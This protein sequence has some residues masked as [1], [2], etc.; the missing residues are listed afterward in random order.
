MLSFILKRVIPTPKLTGFSRYLFI[1][2]HPDDIEVGCAPTVAALT[3]AG[4]HVAF[5]VVTDG[6]V[7]GLDPALTG[8]PLAESRR[9]EALASAKLLGVTDVTFLPFADGGRYAQQD[10]EAALAAVI[11][12][13]QPDVVFAPDPDV[14]AEC[15]PDHLKVGAAAKTCFCMTGFPAL[16]QR[17]GVGGAH[18]V[19]LLALYFTARPNAYIRVSRTF[20]KRMQALALHKTQFDAAGLAAV[21]PYFRLRAVAYG[22]RRLCGKADG[23]RTLTAVQCHCV[24]EFGE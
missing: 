15:H 21:A 11:V 23:Y 20:P 14:S 4:K 18:Q 10:L 6:S 24:P 1:G 12:E 5:V 7:G 9:G 13:K 16:M 19:S 3:A 22:L 2:P 17:I 8:E